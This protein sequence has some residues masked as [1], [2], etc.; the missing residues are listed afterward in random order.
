MDAC[1]TFI[2]VS[3]RELNFQIVATKIGSGSVV[4]ENPFVVTSLNLDISPG[5]G[6]PVSAV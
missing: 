3:G 2:S 4:D 1:K 5:R 6:A